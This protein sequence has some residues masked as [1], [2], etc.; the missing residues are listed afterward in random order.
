MGYHD[1]VGNVTNDGSNAY[2]Y[3]A[4]GRPVTVGGA[5]IVYDAFN[6]AAEWNNGSSHSQVVYDPQGAKLAGGPDNETNQSGYPSIRS[7]ALSSESSP[8]AVGEH[9]SLA[10][11]I[12]DES[13]WRTRVYHFAVKPTSFHQPSIRPSTSTMILLCEPPVPYGRRER[14]INSSI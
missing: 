10:S 12:E 14:P 11:T 3:D 2:S 9:R 5:Q 8:E 4:E 7:K 6:R 1:G 13:H